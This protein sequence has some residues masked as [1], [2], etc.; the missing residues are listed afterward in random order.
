MND[1]SDFWDKNPWL[2]KF[3]D[4]QIQIQNKKRE[5][6]EYLK[7]YNL[8]FLK[9]PS[10]KR[11]IPLKLTDE[12]ANPI[13]DNNIF[14]NKIIYE[15]NHKQNNLQRII[16]ESDENLKRQSFELF[17][18]LGQ[19]RFSPLL[20][21]E[22]DMLGINKK[23]FSIYCNLVQPINYTKT[24][25]NIF[26]PIKLPDEPKKP[27][28]IDYLNSNFN[29]PISPDFGKLSNS[30]FQKPVSKAPKKSG[31]RYKGKPIRVIKRNA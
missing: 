16:R 6:E 24:A 20:T 27:F 10:Q 26:D 18:S 21:D 31:R 8:E 4:E 9:I 7:R 2:K 1:Y 22:L 14:I 19:K 28:V 23:P 15:K 17:K 25:N 3:S 13:L 30:S 5:D 12:Y 29:K 11:F